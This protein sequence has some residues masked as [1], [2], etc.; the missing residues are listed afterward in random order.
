MRRKMATGPVSIQQQVRIQPTRH[1][2]AL[3]VRLIA[4]LV[5]RC[6]QRLR[7]HKRREALPQRGAKV[8]VLKLERVRVAHRPPLRVGH[9]IPEGKAAAALCRLHETCAFTRS[10]EAVDD[11]AI[12]WIEARTVGCGISRRV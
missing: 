2:F 9:W 5:I 12:D 4:L 11:E 8:G 1:P 7:R 3:E 10:E 6:E